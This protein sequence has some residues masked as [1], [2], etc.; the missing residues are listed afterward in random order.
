MI[1]TFYGVQ[2]AAF[3]EFVFRRTL[4]WYAVP[5]ATWLYHHRRPLFREDLDFIRE[6]STLTDAEVFRSE[7][8]RFYG[9]NVRE[10]GWIRGKFGIR[11]SAKR[12]I[13][14]KNRAVSGALRQT[15]AS[16]SIA[17]E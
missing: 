17:R 9:R 5:F 15:K 3:E 13:R 11:I 4:E 6:I 14:L 2:P 1:C 12:M 10:R 16:P 7:L 8:N